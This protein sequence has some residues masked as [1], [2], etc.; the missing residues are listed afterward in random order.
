MS[1]VLPDNT[2]SVK[3]QPIQCPSPDTDYNAVFSGQKMPVT[4]QGMAGAAT[5]CASPPPTRNNS[6]N[7][8][9]STPAVKVESQATKTRSGRNPMRAQAANAAE[10]GGTLG[11]HEEGGTKRESS[12]AR[13][14]GAKDGSHNSSKKGGRAKDQAGGQRKQTSSKA[15]APQTKQPRKQQAGSKDQTHGRGKRHV[16]NKSSLQYLS[17]AG[18][19]DASIATA[20]KQRAD[21]KGHSKSGGSTRNSDDDSTAVGG[22][23]AEDSDFS[24]S[25]YTIGFSQ[26]DWDAEVRGRAVLPTGLEKTLTAQ[27]LHT[28]ETRLCPSAE[29]IE[30]KRAFIE[31]FA[32]ILTVEFPEWEVDIH[33]FG[34]SVNGLGTSRSD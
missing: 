11:V 24:D 28:Y 20:S 9:P 5:A 18:S 22:G 3:V 6:A 13:K 33:V 27:I 25:E 16:R 32:T 31:K 19:S 4:D 2:T 7:C 26:D 34:S 15:G 10:E 21:S 14:A 30:V 8:S 12:G 29:S 1:A 23:H 17:N